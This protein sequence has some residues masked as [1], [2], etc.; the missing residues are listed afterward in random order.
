MELDHIDDTTG[1]PPGEWPRC[2]QGY[3]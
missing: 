1:E 3:G 2:F